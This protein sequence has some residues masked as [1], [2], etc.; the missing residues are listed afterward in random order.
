MRPL[1][2]VLIGLLA[3]AVGCGG[4]KGGPGHDAGGAGGSGGEGGIG[5]ADAPVEPDAGGDAPAVVPLEHVTSVFPAKGATSVCTDAPLRLWF[6]TP[7]VLG[8]RGLVRVFDAANPA[9]PVDSIDLAAA[10]VTQTIGGRIYI[11]KPIP[12]PACVASGRGAG[13][14]QTLRAVATLALKTTLDWAEN[15]PLFSA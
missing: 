7:P 8:A 15:N 4:G 11:H 3:G 14:G 1:P 12:S 6:D 2:Y 5:G 13:R 9:T 10:V